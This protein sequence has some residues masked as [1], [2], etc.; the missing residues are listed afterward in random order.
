M[1]EEDLKDDKYHPTRS[2]PNITLSTRPS[3]APV[4]VP[5]P[6]DLSLLQAKASS[7]LANLRVTLLELGIQVPAQPVIPEVE[8]EEPIKSLQKG[9]VICPVCDKEFPNAFTCKAHYNRMHVGTTGWQCKIC[10]KYF[11]NKSSL[12]RHYEMHSH[13]QFGCALCDK[14]FKSGDL[15]KAHAKTHKLSEE[16]C[17]CQYCMSRK[18]TLAIRRQHETM[19]P[20]NPRAVARVPCSNASKGCGSTFTALKHMNEHRRRAC[21]FEDKD[22]QPRKRPSEK[23]AKK[24]GKKPRKDT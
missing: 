21:N 13:Q 16:S 3:A 11:S 10:Q 5:A 20:M 17:I 12:S 8:I 23:E 18:S 14:R 19:C 9:E 6:A 2:H 4:L 22:K 7:Q 15:L 1:Y 24:P